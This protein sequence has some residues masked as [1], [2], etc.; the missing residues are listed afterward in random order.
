MKKISSEQEKIEFKFRKQAQND[1]KVKNAYL[2]VHSEKL[3]VDI[4]IAEG[5]TEGIQATPE[6]AN[7]LAS[8]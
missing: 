8:V 5:Q 4:N 7:H 2:L 3:G 6:Q 1:K